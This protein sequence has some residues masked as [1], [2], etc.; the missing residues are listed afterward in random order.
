[1]KEEMEAD[2]LSVVVARRPCALLKC[3]KN[4][5]PVRVNEKCINCL[6]CM[7]LG[8]PAIIKTEKG[9]R[10]DASLCTGCGLCTKVCPKGAIEEGGSR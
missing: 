10:I 7:G 2:E 5:P 3:V 9:P 1:M 6:A 4:K 8:C